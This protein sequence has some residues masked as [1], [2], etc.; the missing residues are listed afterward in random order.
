MGA[1]GDESP[2]RFVSGNYRSVLH[3]T[4]KR[5]G[6]TVAEWLQKR[7]IGQKWCCRCKAWHSKTAFGQDSSKYDGLHGACRAS[8]SQFDKSVY[9]RVASKKPAGSQQSPARPGDKKQARR[10]VNLEVRTGRWPHPNTLPCVDC[11]H[12]WFEGSK[13]RHEYDHF[14]GY[15]SMG[16]LK[17]EAVCQACHLIREGMRLREVA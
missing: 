1:A 5:L 13:R 4:A 17:V 14:L 7:D 3:A 15:D 6:I 12:L 16:H 2:G 9:I 11:G 8:R 10:K